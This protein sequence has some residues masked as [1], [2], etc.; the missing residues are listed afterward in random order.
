[1]KVSTQWLAEWVAIDETPAALAERLTLAGLEVDAVDPVVPDFSGVVVARV[2]A[3]EPHPDADRLRVCQVNGGGA[4]Q[5][6]VCGA[7]NVRAGMLVPLATVG[8][9]LP[10]GMKIKQAKLRG[11]P[12]AGM[13]CSAKELGLGEASDGLME[14]HGAFEPGQNFRDAIQAEDHVIEIEL[15]PNR[16]DCA[17]IRGVARDAAVLYAADWSPLGCAPVAATHDDGR[18]VKIEDLA[19]TPVFCGR[20]IRGVDAARPTPT[21]MQERLRRAG[22]RPKHA[23]VDITNYV[24]IELGQPMHAYDDSQLNGPLLARRAAAGESLVLLNEQAI[25]LDERCLVIADDNGPVGL[26]GAMGGAASAVSEATQDLYL[27][28][29]CFVPDAVAGVGRRFKLVSDALYRYERGV[30]PALQRAAMERATA[31]VL[32]ICGGQAGPVREVGAAPDQAPI[33]LRLARLAALLGGVIA[34]DRVRD[35]LSRLGCA[36]QQEGGDQFQVTPPSHRYDLR[37]EEDLVEEVARVIGYDHL[38]G[39]ARTVELQFGRI[40]EDQIDRSRI[41]DVLCGRGYREVITYSFVDAAVDSALSGGLETVAVDNPIAEQLSVMRTTLWS[42]LVGVLK[43]NRARGSDRL[44]IYELGLQFHPKGEDVSQPQ[45]LAGLASGRRLSEHWD[46]DQTPVDFFDIKGDLEA[47]LEQAGKTLQCEAQSH[48]ALHPG[49]SARLMVQGRPVGWLGRL[50]PAVAR[51][52]DLGPA[53]VVFEIELGV[54]LQGRAPAYEPVTDQPSVRRDLAVVCEDSLPVGELLRVCRSAGGSLL[55]QA[56]V[57]DVYRGAGLP[58]SSKSVALSLIF[59][60]KTRT[61]IDREV[62]EAVAKVRSALSA[63]LGVGFRE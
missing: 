16:G 9:V 40:N 46:A 55:R 56:G 28:A 18:G 1:M 31:L 27:E 10:G 35:I 39:G 12:S 19:D 23:L 42:G 49:Q 62:D 33:R 3:V 6:I 26:A 14:L 38:P 61:L 45:V 34:E 20:L 51:Q 43:H 53:P 63:E 60:D 58:D 54:L 59:Q 48:A 8:A 15:T 24:L 30:D 36:V 44:R 13:L 4:M 22:L 32:E 52:L 2:E 29:A 11:V 25:D 50:H 57:F 5:Q 17:S 7:P 41:H 21:W 37:I 47:L